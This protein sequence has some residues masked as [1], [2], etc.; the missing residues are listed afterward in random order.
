MDFR[1]T[2]RSAGIT[3]KQAAQALGINFSTLQQWM[4]RGIP[5][6]SSAL[7]HMWIRGLAH[8]EEHDGDLTVVPSDSV[9]D[10]CIR[11]LDMVV[12][13]AKK[14]RGVI[15][16]AS[17]RTQVKNDL[18]LM[19]QLTSVTTGG[20]IADMR[21]SRAAT[22]DRYPGEKAAQTSISLYPTQNSRLGEVADVYG[23]SKADVLR[24]A[25]EEFFDRHSVARQAK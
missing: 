21:S 23:M 3:Q 24:T 9:I 1:N 19:N 15:R 6:A 13:S 2:I 20:R 8:I 16:W 14:A 22:A 7:A 17:E 18:D 4:R 12:A 10:A 5:G 25:L 11:E